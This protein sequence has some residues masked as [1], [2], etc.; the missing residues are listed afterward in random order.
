MKYKT[1]NGQ[2]ANA[3]EK[4][5]NLKTA[6]AEL[7]S[8][9]E[10]KTRFGALGFR[11]ATTEEIHYLSVPGYEGKTPVNLAN[12]SLDKTGN[13]LLSEAYTQS[14]FDWIGQQLQGDFLP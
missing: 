14:L 11:P 5:A 1:S 6:L 13:P 10:T 2:S 7:L 4:N 9:Q 12:S 8:Y 3:K